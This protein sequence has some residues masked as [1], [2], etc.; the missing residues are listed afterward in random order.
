MK[1]ISF[2][3]AIAA[4]LMLVPGQASAQGEAVTLDNVTGLFS[5][6]QIQAG[7][8]VEF[9]IRMN[10]PSA[11]K[12]TFAA[13][14]H[15]F[16]PDGATW[17]GTS[18]D[19]FGN[20]LSAANFALGYSITVQSGDGALYDTVGFLAAGLPSDVLMP[21]GF[22]DVPF[23]IT[24]A[25]TNLADSNK[26]LCID[27]V[28]FFG[29]GGNWKWVLGS[30][31]VFP[32]WSGQECWTIFFVPNL[33]PV[34]S[35]PASITTSHCVD[36]V[37]AQYTAVDPEPDPVTDYQVVTTG[38]V[39]AA[40]IT[41]GGA[42]SWTP[43]LADVGASIS[44]D[45]SAK[46]GGGSGI[47]GAAFTTNVTVTNDAPVISGCPTAIIQQSAGG[48]AIIQLGATDADGCETLIWS[49]VTAVAPV[50]AVGVD[51]TGKVTYTPDPLDAGSIIICVEVFDGAKA[52]TC[53]IEFDVIIGAPYSIRIEKVEGPDSLGVLQGQFHDVNIYLDNVGDGGLGGFDLLIAY[54]ASALSFQQA[55]EGSIYGACNWEYF[56]YRYGANGN[57]SGG[58]PSGLLRVVG[59]AETNNGPAHPIPDCAAA[60]MTLASLRFYVSNDRTLECQFVPIRFFWF[61]CGDNTVSDEVGV[62]YI[63]ALVYDFWDINETSGQAEYILIDPAL[64]ALPGY[65]GL[66]SGN[67]CVYEP[68]KTEPTVGIDFYNGGIDIICADSI[69]ARGDVNLNGLAYEIADAVMFTNYFLSGIS[70]FGVNY[71]GS[72]AATD[73]NADGIVLSVAD[74]V[75]LIRVVVGDALPYPKVNPTIVNY[76]TDK[77]VVSVDAEMGAAFVVVEGN[78]NPVNLTAD[79][80]MKFAFD[81]ENTNVL[82]Y[83]LEKG[84]SFSG[85]FLNAGGNVITVEMATYDGAPVAGV[86][87]PRDYALNQNYPNPFNPSTT[88]SFAVPVA[89][90]VN[91]AIYNVTGQKVADLA[92]GSYE[93]GVHDVMWDAGNYSSGVYFYKLTTE[94]YT[95][96][97]KMVLV[98]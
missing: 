9:F 36:P 25:G 78:V 11:N 49:D 5:P 90:N 86:Y 84:E 35:G 20:I 42:L 41:S 8:D 46:D 34:V 91:L 77:N 73:V 61:D 74:L 76:S 37:Q 72:I 16:S 52:D 27:T 97:R 70:A 82:V 71:E 6:T 29:T 47:F 14:F 7:A 30:L 98:K 88:I 50:G 66:D 93:A 1:R 65:A 85:E 23:S 57:C 26:T 19:T 60:G 58:C 54:D 51:Q 45:V 81:G 80:D 96:T 63:A 68:G 59:I 18:G 22:N 89:G 17:A 28:G 67:I 3:L 69:D 79:M 40:T 64:A 21:A 62:L 53:C 32:T 55:L 87:V 44:F 12:Y 38:A 24:A 33:P 4:L 94:N 10:N 2:F 43:T 95:E 48:E 56:T 39:N 75:Y 15:V 31:T 92:N 13:G 83:S